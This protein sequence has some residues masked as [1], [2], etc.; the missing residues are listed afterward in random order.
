M[1]NSWVE[2]KDELQ[3]LARTVDKSIVLKT[4]DCWFAKFIAVFAGIFMDK[5][6]FVED[7]AF[8][9]ANF[10]F[11]HES[12]T[13][14]QVLTTILH[15]S[16]HTRQFRWF[17]FGIHPL[18]GVPLYSIVYLLVPFFVG[19]AYMRFWFELD[20]ERF[21]SREELKRGIST[22]T[23]ILAR[24]KRFG[25]VVCSRDYFWPW[26][27]AW[28]IPAFERMGRQVVEEVG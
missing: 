5:K 6:S 9:T 7:F 10:Q 1:T 22:P 26:P 18:V 16:R 23:E 13:Y 3:A 25:A 24:V 28:G 8:T 14:G 2:R 12:W 27:A 4:K 17:G 19:V 21:S 15:E 20:A 11:Y